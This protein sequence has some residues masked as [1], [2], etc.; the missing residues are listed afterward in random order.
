[1]AIRREKAIVFLF[2]CS[3]TYFKYLNEI[4]GQ[5]PPGV[6]EKFGEIHER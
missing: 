1:V 3:L 4:E 2:P 6:L 5:A